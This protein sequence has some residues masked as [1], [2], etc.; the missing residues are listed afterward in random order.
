MNDGYTK[1]V[2]LLK[3]KP[4]MSFE[5]FQQYYENT[6]CKFIRLIPRVQRYFRRYLHPL[7]GHPV[8][9]RD[10]SLEYHVITELWFNSR[11]DLDFAMRRNAE[12][13]VLD[14][15]IPDEEKL[16]DRSKT[17]VNIV[18]ERYSDLTKDI[19]APG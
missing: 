8:N 15:L 1:L 7:E 6:H 16:F 5:E 13:D 12:P 18:E 3:K 9:T 2:V 11:E 14:V 17:R 10:D 4:G 19:P